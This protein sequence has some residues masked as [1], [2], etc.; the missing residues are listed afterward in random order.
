MQLLCGW[1]GAWGCQGGA[2]KMGRSLPGFVGHDD[3]WLGESS[4]F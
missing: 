4:A 1:S 2:M 3:N